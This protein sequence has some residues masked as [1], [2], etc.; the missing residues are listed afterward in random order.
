MKKILSLLLAILMVAFAVAGCGTEKVENKVLTLS[1]IVEENSEKEQSTFTGTYTGE[2]KSDKPHGN[3]VF[4]TRDKENRAVTYSGRFKNG[5][6]D[7]AAI[8]ETDFEKI[9]IVKEESTFSEGKRNGMNKLYFYGKLFMEIE[10]K[11][12]EFTGKMK[13]Y[14]KNGKL[15]MEF[16]MDDFKKLKED[17]KKGI[18]NPNDMDEKMSGRVK[19]YYESGQLKFDGKYQASKPSEGTLY[20]KDG[21]IQYQGKFVNGKPAR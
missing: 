14:H 7:G 12:G 4:K 15:A 16:E 19:E 8:I 1:P 3:G 20:N 18:F 10:Y 11:D 9:G 5:K 13:M 21:S 2:L 6:L 17:A